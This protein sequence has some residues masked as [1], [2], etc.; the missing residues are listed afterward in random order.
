MSSV[1][2]LTP[3]GFRFGAALIERH[4]SLPD[5]RVCVGVTTDA[6]RKLDIYVSAAGRSVR[7]FEKGQEY[8]RVGLA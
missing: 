5:G 3:Y 8:A 7:I 6:G 2:E 1:A 4:M